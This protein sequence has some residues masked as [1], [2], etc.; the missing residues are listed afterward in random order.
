[1]LEDNQDRLVAGLQE[2]YCRLT[3]LEISG[4][5]PL[6][7]T[8][9]KPTAH[10]ILQAL[11]L[12]GEEN[13]SCDKSAFPED[14]Q[15]PLLCLSTGKIGC[16][17]ENEAVASTPESGRHGLAR[18]TACDKPSGARSTL[19]I[20]HVSSQNTTSSLLTRSLIRSSHPDRQH[21][22]APATRL[23]S[24]LLQYANDRRAAIA[25][26]TLASN[27]LDCGSGVVYSGRAI[28]KPDLGN[29]LNGTPDFRRDHVWSFDG[30]GFDQRSRYFGR[31]DLSSAT[32]S[33][34]DFTDL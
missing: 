12:L 17:S 7:E 4:I 23:L 1:M 27:D 10:K 6:A 18:L 31:G 34:Q 16:L 13:N 11:G 20:E 8:D 15:R 3:K 9:H 30:T 5:P 24:H 2:L 19:P 14:R 21:D 33:L 22:R 29:G 25:D 28:P 26:P 32:D